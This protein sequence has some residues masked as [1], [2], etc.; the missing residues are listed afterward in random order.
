MTVHE[1]RHAFSGWRVA[2]RPTTSSRHSIISFGFKHGIP[3]DSDLLFD[4]RSCRIRI[5]TALRTH[6][7]GYRGGQYRTFG[8]ATRVSRP[9]RSRAEFNNPAIRPR[10]KVEAADGIATGRRQR[11]VATRRP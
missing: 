10:G 8:L 1:L 5:R 6:T 11:S 7:A 3:V 2:R 9:P 4:V